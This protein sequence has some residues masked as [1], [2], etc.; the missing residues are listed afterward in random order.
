METRSTESLLKIP[1]GFNNSVFWNIAHLLVTPQLLC[2]R[3]S[4]MDLMIDE[5]M[6][7]KYGKGSIATEEVSKEEF[8]FVKNNL[9]ETMKLLKEDYAKGKFEHFKPYMTSTGIELLNID[10]VLKF[11]GFHD[12]IHLGVVLSLMKVT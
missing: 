3:L 1:E 5:D 4:G 10:D 12:G 2:Y 8:E 7:T 9:L 6:V 11:S